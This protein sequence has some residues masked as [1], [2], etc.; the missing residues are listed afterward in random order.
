[1]ELAGVGIG[2]T[3][4]GSTCMGF[5]S[6]SGNL[7]SVRCDVEVWDRDRERDLAVIVEPFSGR[8]FAMGVTA[9]SISSAN[10]RTPCLLGVSKA[11]SSEDPRSSTSG[12]D[13]INATRFEGVFCS[14]PSN[15]ESF[16]FKADLLG[17][18]ETERDAELPRCDLEGVGFVED[19]GE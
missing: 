14:A 11:S 19:V 10:S 8:S 5:S 15:A 7:P 18:F 4:G 9:A 2:S 1:M 17:D 6:S 13:F 12:T 3:D 16:R